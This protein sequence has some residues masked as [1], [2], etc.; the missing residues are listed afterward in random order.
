MFAAR[1]QRAR[2]AGT[3]LLAAAVATFASAPTPATTAPAAPRL[4]EAFPPR[5]NVETA[6]RFA[7]GRRGVVSLAVI[8]GRGREHGVASGR[9]YISASVSK[10]MLLVAYLGRVR[11]RAL[12]GFERA[13]LRSMITVSDNGAATAIHRRVGD[14]ALRRLARRAGMRHFSVHGSW[15]RSHF[16]ASDMARFFVRFDRL[17]PARHRTFARGLLASV[18]PR[19]RWGFAPA[20]ARTRFRIFFKGGWRATRRGR[21][22]HQAAML[23]RGVGRIALVVLTDGNPSHRYG[24]ATLGGVAERVLSSAGTRALRRSGLVSLH[25]YALGLALDLRYAG[26]RNLT[27]RRLPGYCRPW[28]MLRA[29]AA[30]DLARVER[31]LNRR[32]L[33]LL[34][35]DAYRPARASRALVRWALRTGRGRLVGSYIARRSN[36]NKGSAVDVTITRLRNG[37]PLDMGTRYDTLSPRS[38]TN[39][40]E[41]R[42]LRNR[43]TLVRAMTRHGWTN[44]RREWWHFDHRA[45]GR[46]YLDVPLGCGREAR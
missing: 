42:V 28:A 19:Q 20:A 10:A 18:V 38:H 23:E 29:R 5:A 46:R 31:D 3:P 26:R 12:S 25:R 44:Y 45:G 33:G 39:A 34:V 2:L 9:T 36:H 22:V 7:R 11:R 6:A 24:A 1:S 43:L 4:G 41:V 37:R 15:A 14:A 40:A 16:S 13:V 8:D 32:G 35:Y 30:R 17:A 21:L 27:G